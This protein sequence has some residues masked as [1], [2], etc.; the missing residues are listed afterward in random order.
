MQRATKAAKSSI[1][2]VAVLALGACGTSGDDA[3][4]TTEPATTTEA[5]APDDTS[6][7]GT[8]TSADDGPDDEATTTEAAPD[9]PTNLD[10][11]PDCQ[12]LLTQYAEA[13]DPDDMGEVIALFR[14]WAPLSPDEV[15]SAMN[16][17]ADAYEEV[18]GDMGEI[19]LTDV[20]LTADAETFSDW[21][22]D[23]CPAG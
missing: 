1:A 11:L 15:A 16:N 21:T 7:D 5:A 14:A 2:L 23:G 3:T 8:T 13:F 17:L 12:A 18:D 20:D 22:N 19:D 4:P 10:E 9:D 6:T